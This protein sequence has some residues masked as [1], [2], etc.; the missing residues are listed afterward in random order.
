PDGGSLASR[1]RNL[2]TTG[3]MFIAPCPEGVIPGDIL[4]IELPVGDRTVV[5]PS[6]IVAWDGEVLRVAFAELT[7]RQQRD[8]VRIVLCRADAWLD[9][10][11]HPVDRPLRAV[12]EILMSI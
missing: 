4:Q 11:E 3:G 9:W 1:S 7:L 5:L 8:L 2:S 6:R 12:R 10:E